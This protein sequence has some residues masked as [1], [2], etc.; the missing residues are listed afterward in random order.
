[1]GPG[2]GTP[3]ASSQLLAFL[4]CTLV[5]SVL[6]TA[7]W[8]LVRRQRGRCLLMP[9]A[10]VVIA[11][12][13][14]ILVGIDLGAGGNSGILSIF[15]AIVVPIYLGAFLIVVALAAALIS[16]D[17]TSGSESEDVAR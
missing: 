6:G 7:I 17:S 8:V 11:I 10:C 2:F 13:C 16:G 1:M 14:A 3:S 9:R 15:S 4:G 5:G 12:V